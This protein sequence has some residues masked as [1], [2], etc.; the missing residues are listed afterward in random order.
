M[1][2]EKADK[3]KKRL[4]FMYRVIIVVNVLL[5]Y[6]SFHAMMTVWFQFHPKK[7]LILYTDL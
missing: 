3:Q 4:Y 6:A 2:I 7:K 1:R 5:I